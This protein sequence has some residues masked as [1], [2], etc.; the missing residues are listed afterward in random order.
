LDCQAPNAQIYELCIKCGSGRSLRQV[1]YA[2]TFVNA[3]E[4]I[5]KPKETH[6]EFSSAQSKTKIFL[7]LPKIYLLRANIVF[8]K[9]LLLKLQGSIFVPKI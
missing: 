9:L 6:S 1:I 3:I 4:Q 8:P 2:A 5:P 7:V